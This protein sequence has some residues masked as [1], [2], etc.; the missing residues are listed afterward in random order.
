MERTVA[1]KSQNQERCFFSKL[2]RNIISGVRS[3]VNA[4]T[5]YITDLSNTTKI[6]EIL[7][8]YSQVIFRK[9]K[10]LALKDKHTRLK[11]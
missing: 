11:Q 2:K 1:L 8:T 4:I 5:N 10:I 6:L 7:Q 3:L 9:R